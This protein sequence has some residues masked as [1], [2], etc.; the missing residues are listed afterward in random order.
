MLRF[1][2][3]WALLVPANAQVYKWVDEKGKTHYGERPPQ[4]KSAKEV[5]Q[6]LA[7]PGAAPGTAA[8]PSWKEQD[9]EFRRRRIES[10]QTEAA[11]KQE[12]DAQRRACKQAR[13]RLALYKSARGVFSLDEK[14]ERVYQSD[15]ERNA[16]NARLEQQISEHCR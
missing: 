8:Q 15:N 6:R 4:G 14:G 3:L 1:C 12:Q 10:D 11:R 2:I 7:N 16:A 5:E 13:D 9:I